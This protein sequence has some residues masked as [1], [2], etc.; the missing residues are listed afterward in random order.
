MNNFRLVI[1]D[2][3][4][5]NLERDDAKKCLND[6]VVMKQTNFLRTDPN[7]VVTDKHDIVGTHFLIYETSNIYNPKVI[8]AL[9]ATYED[10]C[11]QHHLTTPFQ[12]LVPKL[13]H[14]LQQAYNE[15]HQEHPILVDCNSW[16]V[17]LNYS[18]KKSGFRLSDIGYTMAYLH[19]TRMGHNHMMGCTNEKYKAHRW[20]E[21]IGS[22]KKGHEFVHPVVPDKHMMILVEKFNWEFLNSV[23]IEY[24]S[25]FDNIYEIVPR[26]LGYAP[27]YDTI[28]S[29]FDSDAATL[30]KVG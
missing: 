2:Y 25:L 22:F 21:N 12:D 7:Y 28:K 17:D 4:M 24:Q 8:F 5:K 19:L 20:L 23:Y 29:E 11:V 3:V 27:I 30:K 1:L 26:E 13:P 6:L 14:S 18:Q 9:R 16:C 10:R 15:F